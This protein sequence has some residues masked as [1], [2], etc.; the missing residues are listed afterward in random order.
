MAKILIIDDKPGVRR[1][2]GEGLASLGYTVIITGEPARAPEVIRF[3]NPD[4][5]LVDPH[6]KH[7]NRS[8]LMQEICRED[9]RVPIL[10]MTSCEGCRTD[11][12]LSYAMDIL[13][14]GSCF[15]D[16][17]RKV[18]ELLEAKPTVPYSADA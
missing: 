9:A 4:L 13:I 5:L 2:F 6:F 7:E 12:R 18:G 3:E 1:V 8:N 14:P 10:I 11:S 15:E 17:S 16:L